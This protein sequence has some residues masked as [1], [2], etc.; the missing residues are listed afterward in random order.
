M[1]IGLLGGA[2]ARMLASIG[3]RVAGWGR[4]P[5]T[6]DGIKT[7]HGPEG[8]APF[9]ARTEILVCLLP[10]TRETRHIVDRDALYALPRGAKLINCGRGGTVDEAAL[11]ARFDG[12]RKLLTPRWKTTLPCFFLRFNRSAGKKARRAKAEVHRL[13]LGGDDDPDTCRR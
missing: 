11:L 4:S 13:R 6:V 7:Y 2:A 8:L 12:N 1:G 3:F 5:R 10:L 9:L